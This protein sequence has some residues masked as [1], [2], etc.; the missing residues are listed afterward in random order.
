MKKKLLVLILSMMLA[1]MC[2]G[3][4]AENTTTDTVASATTEESTPAQ[5][6]EQSDAP[7]ETAAPTPEPTAEPTPEPTEAP[8]P[9]P[10]AEPTPEP[11]AEPT[12]EPAPQVVYTYTDM[13]ATMYATQTVNMRDLPSTDGAK[14]GSLSTNQEVAVNGQCNETGW[15]RFDYNGQTAFVSNK[16]LSTEMVEVATPADTNSVTTTECPYPLNQII[17]EGGDRVCF[18]YVGSMDDNGGHNM[19][20]DCATIIAERHGWT[21]NWPSDRGGNAGMY[22]TNVKTNYT[23]NGQPVYQALPA[24]YLIGPNGGGPANSPE[25]YQCPVF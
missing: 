19:T 1:S 23:Y 8:T 5:I 3:C 18:F 12:P 11:T 24:A 17:D 22:G 9:D 16:Y 14:V 6:T 2:V 25:I 21:T 20:Y 13:S 7:A 15:Y 10:T 4:G